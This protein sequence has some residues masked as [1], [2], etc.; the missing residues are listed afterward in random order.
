MP[1]VVR[2]LHRS[3]SQDRAGAGGRWR[4]V[5][6]RASAIIIT[7]SESLNEA[8]ASLSLIT[9]IAALISSVSCCGAVL[10]CCCAALC[11]AVLLITAVLL[12]CS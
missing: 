1:H 6:E 7:S 4:C 2:A 12:L 10:L 11:C 3:D 5:Q 9:V 8:L